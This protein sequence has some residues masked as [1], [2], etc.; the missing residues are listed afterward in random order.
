MNS[1]T[2]YTS[3]L[4]SKRGIVKNNNNNKQLQL[5]SESSGFAQL[6]KSNFCRM[7]MYESFR[8]EEI[9]FIVNL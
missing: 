2:H 1:W 6:T 5:C 4:R 8:K 9:N 3:L 7:T